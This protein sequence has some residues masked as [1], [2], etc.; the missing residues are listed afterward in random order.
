MLVLLVHSKVGLGFVLSACV[1]GS[2]CR[3]WVSLCSRLC[4]GPGSSL[5]YFTWYNTGGF[6]V[7][8]IF[9]LAPVFY[10]FPSDEACIHRPAMLNMGACRRLLA[11][12]LSVH[13]HMPN[14]Y[15]RVHVMCVCVFFYYYSSCEIATKTSSAASF[16]RLRGLVTLI[17]CPV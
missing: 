17:V 13:I 10:G 16:Y 7:L 4:F 15:I 5:V 9:A 8:R 3:C 1:C 2:S 11:R 12:C 14:I 6:L